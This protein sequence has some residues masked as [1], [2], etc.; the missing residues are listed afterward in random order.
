MNH[1]EGNREERPGRFLI[2]RAPIEKHVKMC[3]QLNTPPGHVKERVY[4]K[5]VNQEG[6]A[7]RDGE[8]KAMRKDETIFA[9][10]DKAEMRKSKFMV[11][12]NSEFVHTLCWQR[13]TRHYVGSGRSGP[14]AIRVNGY[15][16]TKTDGYEPNHNRVCWHQRPSTQ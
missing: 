13:Y 4:P 9:A 5:Q 2:T 11:V 7:Q 6:D 8:L 12:A 16:S 14:T 15:R 10:Y 3:S 1:D